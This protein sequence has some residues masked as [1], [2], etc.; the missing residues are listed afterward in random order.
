MEHPTQPA[1]PA[2]YFAGPSP[3]LTACAR[4][5]RRVPA[6][7]VAVSY[8]AVEG[9][10]AIGY[11]RERFTVIH[12][13]I[14]T[15]RYRQSPA[16]RTAVREELG[17]SEHGTLVIGHVARFHP[18]KDHVGLIDTVAPML[19]DRP[20]V[21]LVLVGDSTDRAA[22]L[23]AANGVEAQV[24]VLGRRTDVPRLTS[25][26]DVAVSSSV[27]EGL[28]NVVGEAMASEVP[29]VVTDVGDS[30]LLVGDTGLVVPARDPAALRTALETVLAWPVSRRH[31]VGRRARARIDAPISRDARNGHRLRAAV[32]ERGASC[33]GLAACTTLGLD[34]GR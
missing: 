27:D 33:A 25:A 18:Q 28:P 9:H 8:A 2:T 6:R 31:E 12:N 10:V 29:C 30:A 11:D 22:P 15:D 13:G 21:V 4:L 7:I 20:G 1:D 34:A 16:D 17:L 23:A 32:R 19:R 14:D 26:F 3:R 5:S 24:R